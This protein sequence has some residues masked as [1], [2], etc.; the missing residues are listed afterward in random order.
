[1]SARGAANSRL[2]GFQ[3]S[4]GEPSAPGDLLGRCVLITSCSFFQ[5]NR[6]FKELSMLQLQ[7]CLGLGV[8]G[9]MNLNFEVQYVS[10]CKEFC[11]NL[12]RFD[13]FFPSYKI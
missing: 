10:N 4:D 12:R 5:C 2:N 3:D 9:N 13:L 11:S 6:P 1:M 8:S 7:A